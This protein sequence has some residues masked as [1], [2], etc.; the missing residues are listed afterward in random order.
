MCQKGTCTEG[1]VAV[2]TGRRC[3]AWFGMNYLPVL[4]PSGQGRVGDR[5]RRRQAHRA[6]RRVDPTPG[7]AGKPGGGAP[8]DGWAARRPARP[9]SQWARAL[10]GG[11]VDVDRDDPTAS[12]PRFTELDR[13]FQVPRVHTQARNSHPGPRPRAYVAEEP[14]L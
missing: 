8:G 11:A 3:K 7:N 9:Q 12:G 10:L 2:P 13:S 6:S 14:P 1:R 5:S 4:G